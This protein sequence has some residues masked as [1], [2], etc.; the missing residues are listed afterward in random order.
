RTR[1]WAPDYSAMTDAEDLAAL[2]RKLQVGPARIV[3]HSYG[4][5]AALFLAA[6]YP[7]LVRSMVLSEPPLLTWLNDLPAGQPLLRDFMDNVWAPAGQA[8]R[9]H[10][11]QAALSVTVEWFGSHEDSSTTPAGRP[12]FAT[13]SPGG[14]YIFIAECQGVGSPY[15]LAKCVSVSRT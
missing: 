1:T 5:Y 14:A 13:L 10:D 11:T 6:K 7:E 12:T 3:G 8:F 15:D 4:A 2:I 9:R